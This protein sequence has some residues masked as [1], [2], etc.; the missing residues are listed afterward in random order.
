MRLIIS[1]SGSFGNKNEN[2]IT[3]GLTVSVHEIQRF[4][5]YKN[6]R[7]FFF[8]FFF[9]FVFFFNVSILH[10]AVKSE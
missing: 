1:E 4:A 9:F 8:F 10:C 6:W 3:L 5:S 7:F 2:N